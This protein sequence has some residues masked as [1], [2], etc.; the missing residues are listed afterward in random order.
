MAKDAFDDKAWDTAEKNYRL[1]LS[2]DE[3]DQRA[4]EGLNAVLSSKVGSRAESPHRG[5]QD[6]FA[7]VQPD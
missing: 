6:Q 7:G 1:A 4:L 3:E 2:L 5:N